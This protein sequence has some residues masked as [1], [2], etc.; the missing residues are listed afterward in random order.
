VLAGVVQCAPVSV[1]ELDSFSPQ[2]RSG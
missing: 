1:E 2:P